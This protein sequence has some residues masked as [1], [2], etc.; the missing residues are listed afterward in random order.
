[1]RITW[2]AGNSKV[3]VNFYD[4]GP[5]KSLVQIEHSKLA[6]AD[7]VTA[8]KAYWSEGLERLRARL[9]T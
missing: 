3:D 8:Q 5:G 9:E 2:T 7:A 6:D 1:M 4:K